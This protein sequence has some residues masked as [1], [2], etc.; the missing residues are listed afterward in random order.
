MSRLTKP[1]IQIAGGIWLNVV[2]GDAVTA[3]PLRQG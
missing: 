2:R 3:I 1:N